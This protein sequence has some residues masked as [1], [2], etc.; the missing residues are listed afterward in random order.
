MSFKIEAV[1]RAADG[2]TFSTKQ[3]AMAYMRKPLVLAA[4]LALGL[5]AAN[6][7]LLHGH[8]DTVEA[9]FESGTLRRVTRQEAKKVKA[10][11]DQLKAMTDPHK[12]LA[13]LIE[14]AD[15]FV[16]SFKWPTQKR[17]SPEE[18]EVM[19]RNTLNGIVGGSQELTDWVLTNK[20]AVLEAFQ[21]GVEKREI[22]TKALDGLAAYQAKKKAE[23]EAAEAAKGGA[24][25][26]APAENDLV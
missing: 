16:D 24:A 17:M 14:N 23:R 26:E 6:A 2:T 19:A 15:A 18:K 11:F 4:L 10:G 7:E 3:E 5:T 8:A 22:S 1:Y 13:F 21:A 25:D 20:D 12:D 9:A